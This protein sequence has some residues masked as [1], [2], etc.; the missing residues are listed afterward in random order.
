MSVRLQNPDCV[1]SAVRRA[2]GDEIN[3]GSQLEGASMLLVDQ[4]TP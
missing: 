3:V 1:I 2:I 4:G